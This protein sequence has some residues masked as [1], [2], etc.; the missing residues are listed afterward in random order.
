MSEGLI[1]RQNN[2]AHANPNLAWAHRNLA[3]VDRI[4]PGQAN[5][6]AC[7]ARGSH[8]TA[9]WWLTPPGQPDQASGLCDGHA[10]SLVLQIRRAQWRR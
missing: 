2:A 3:G 8:N 1:L 7:M 4:E 6:S 9:T 5:C 10:L